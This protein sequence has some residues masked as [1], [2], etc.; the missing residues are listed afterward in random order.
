MSQSHPRPSQA[1]TAPRRPSGALLAAM[2]A[3]VVVALIGAPWL[4]LR[5]TSWPHAAAAGAFVAL[6]PA[7]YAWFRLGQQARRGTAVLLALAY[8][9][10]A[11]GL[12]WFWH[13]R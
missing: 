3:L 9:A 5:L 1:R 8:A 10:V 13:A 6:V 7:L 2:A 12:L 11:A 4:A